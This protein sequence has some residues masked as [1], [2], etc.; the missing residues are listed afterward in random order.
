MPPVYC[1]AAAA[2]NVRPEVVRLLGDCVIVVRAGALVGKACATTWW[3]RTERS[4]VRKLPPPASL[5]SSPKTPG[6]RV[7]KGSRFCLASMPVIGTHLIAGR[8]LRAAG[9]HIDV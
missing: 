6:S 5:H 4:H 1:S 9:P 3:A 8:H 2:R 7:A